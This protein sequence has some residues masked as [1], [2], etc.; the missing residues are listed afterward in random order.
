MA[1]VNPGEKSI[2]FSSAFVDQVRSA[3]AWQGMSASEYI[4]SL[5][6]DRAR[7]DVEAS[8]E[9]IRE[10]QELEAELAKPVA[11]EDE[12]DIGFAAAFRACAAEALAQG[13]E[14]VEE[15]LGRIEEAL[16]DLL[17]RT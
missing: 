2:K 4:I 11:P 9:R 17:R 5:V 1:R 14:D 3:A 8:H 7:R 16:N 12:E 10:M 13:G 6:G 15:Q